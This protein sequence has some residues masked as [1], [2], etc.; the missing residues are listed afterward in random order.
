[1]DNQLAL[2]GVSKRTGNEAI[3]GGKC[4]FFSWAKKKM[5]KNVDNQLA[6]KQKKGGQPAN[7]LAYISTVLALKLHHAVTNSGSSGYWTPSGDQ[8]VHGMYP[9]HCNPHLQ[10]AYPQEKPFF[11]EYFCGSCRKSC[12]SQGLLPEDVL[13]GKS[14]S[15]GKRAPA[16]RG[17]YLNKFLWND[18]HCSRRNL[19]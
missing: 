7:S 16:G 8:L 10:T 4:F 9:K 15:P 19:W 1:M 13:S 2:K 14:P 6:L 18:S 12:K 17:V 3:T 5:E 11:S